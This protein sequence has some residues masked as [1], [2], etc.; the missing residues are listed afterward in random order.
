MEDKNNIIEE[1]LNSR[2]K[3][4]IF[5]LKLLN[6]NKQSAEDLTQD[7]IY[8]AINSL[9]NLKNCDNIGGWLYTITRNIFINNY[10][11]NKKK[12][13]YYVGDSFES[14]FTISIADSYD[15]VQDAE[16]NI[17]FVM[18]QLNRAKPKYKECIELHMVGS[19]IEEIAHL[20][21]IPSGTVKSRIFMGRKE[22]KGKI[23]PV[24]ENLDF[25][26]RD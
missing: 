8:K 24:L 15:S 14:I 18:A 19:K 26:I 17:D 11:K 9:D 25:E 1:I 3:L 6:N 12:P 4:F 13:T 5:S 21:N 22:L 20:L 16:S 23:K 10:R 2:Q 7:A